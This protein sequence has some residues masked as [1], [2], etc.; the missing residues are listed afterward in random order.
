MIGVLIVVLAG[1]ACSVLGVFLRKGNI[2]LLHS[3]HRERVSPSD[4]IPLGKATGNGMFAIGGGMLGFGVL[5]IGTL[6]TENRVFL[7]A[8]M[9]LMGLGL[10][11]GIGMI[12]YA[13]KKY[14]KS[15][16]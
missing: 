10:A 15:I 6:L 9:A 7:W 11:V 2:E 13:L 4:R 16:F 8:G 12:F 5:S 1:A 3:Y 14:N